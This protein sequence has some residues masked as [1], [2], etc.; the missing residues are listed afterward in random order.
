MQEVLYLTPVELC[1][2]RV[3]VVQLCFVL[4]AV[5]VEFGFV[6]VAVAVAVVV[7]VVVVELQTVQL[8][9]D[10]SWAREKSLEY[11]S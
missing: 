2:R 3:V 8:E 6:V 5:F 1:L 7:V 9:V 4:V 10:R 11:L